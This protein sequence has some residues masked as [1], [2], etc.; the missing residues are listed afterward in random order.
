MTGAETVEAIAAAV[1]RCGTV[2]RLHGGR[3]N[4]ITSYLPGRRVS[5]VA[6][7]PSGVTVGLV[8]RYPATVAEIAAQVRA[9]V[10]AVVPDVAVTLAV[11]DIDLADID[12]P[13]VD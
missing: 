11:E 3:F 9:A 5:G 4:A 2:A 10:S 1:L 8:G 13:G 7:T 6:V 12:L